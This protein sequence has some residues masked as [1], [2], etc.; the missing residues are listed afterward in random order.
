MTAELPQNPDPADRT[1]KLLTAAAQHAAPLSADFLAELRDRTT[2]EFQQTQRDSSQ[3]LTSS[4]RWQMLFV[5]ALTTAIATAAV[6]SALWFTHHP[7]SG[8]PTGPKWA[9]HERPALADKPIMLAF[10]NLTNAQ[11]FAA[12]LEVNGEKQS[13]SGA[14]NGLLRFDTEPGS[15]SIVNR[16]QTWEVNEADNRAEPAAAEYFYRRDDAVALNPWRLMQLEPETGEALAYFEEEGT[17]NNSPLVASYFNAHFRGQP[18]AVEAHVD[19]VKQLPR[20]LL[21]W[22]RENRGALPLLRF[23]LTQAGG[24]ADATKFKLAETL[25]KDGRIGKIVDLQG[26]VTVR[27]LASS[28]WTPLCNA[29]TLLVP[30][31]WLRTDNRG[32]NAATVQLAPQ[33]KLIVGPGTLLEL[34]KPDQLRLTTGVLQITA[35]D[36]TPVTITGPD[37][38]QV[39]VKG[40]EIWHVAQNK[41]QKLKKEPLWLTGYLGQATQETLGSLIALVDGRNVPLTV[42]YHKVHVEIRDQIA[43]TTIEESFVNHTQGVLE[44]KFY[45]PLP[46][47]ASISG[48][49]MWIGDKLVEADIVEKQRAREIY[50]TILREKR[51]PGLL[52][53]TGGN[54]FQARV[55]PIP[56]RSEKR[57]KITYTQVLPL[58][59]DSYRYS[60][61]LQSDLLKQNP[62]RKLELSVNIHS[63]QPLQQVVCPTHPTRTP[64]E[65]AAHSNHLA[66][67][68]FSAQDYTPTR[69]FEVVTTL[70]TRNQD[71]TLI[72]HQRGEDGFFM[73]LMQPPNHSGQ[74]KRP[75]VNDGRPLELL[76]LADT[77]ASMDHASRT[78][79]SEVIAALLGSLAPNDKFNL[80]VCDVDCVW[81]FDKTVEAIPEQITKA[82]DVLL[83]RR[84]MGWTNLQRGWESALA[85]SSPGAHIIYVGDGIVTHGTQD[86][87][88]DVQAIAAVAKGKDVL[89]HAIAVSSS[90][91]SQLLK[92][93][94]A[95][96]GGSVRHAAGEVKPTQIAHELLVEAT[97][98]ALRN[99]QVS[100]A[101]FRTAAVYPPTLANLP[102]GTQQ[103]VLGRYLPESADKQGEVIVSGTLDG[104]PVA[105]R[106]AVDLKQVPKA[107]SDDDASFIPRLWARLHL[108]ELLAQGSSQATQDQ[109][110]ALS[111]EYHIITPYTSLLVLE[112]DADRERFKVKKRV[113]MRDGER[114][115]QK[116]NNNLRYALIQQQLQQAQA[117]RQ[118]LR[119]R[120]LERLSN[121]GR[122]ANLLQQTEFD[123]LVSLINSTIE[124]NSWYDNGITLLGSGEMAGRSSGQGRSWN[125]SAGGNGGG[126]VQADF[127]FLGETLHAEE[128]F[129][130]RVD[131]LRRFDTRFGRT[132]NTIL[133]SDSLAESIDGAS[134]LE[135]LQEWGESKGERWSKGLSARGTSDGESLGLYAYD[136]QPQLLAGIN[137]E[138]HGEYLAGG[139]NF[140]SSTF[141]MNGDFDGIS[142][143]SLSDLALHDARTRFKR[144]RQ[145]AYMQPTRQPLLPVPPPL[146]LPK[147]QTRNVKTTWPADAIELLR[148]L[149]LDTDLRKLPGGLL[150]DRQNDAFDVR[151]AVLSSR[152]EQRQ[153]YSPAAWLTRGDR[154]RETS[155]LL[156]WCDQHER[157]NQALAFDLAL[158]RK[159]DANDLQFLPELLNETGRWD[160]LLTDYQVKLE[161]PAE[162]LVLL[163]AKA[164]DAV[165]FG[166]EE[167]RWLIDTEQRIVLSAERRYQDKLVDRTEF[168]QFVQIAGRTFATTA[169][170]FDAEG[171]RTG[172]VILKLKELNAADFRATWDLEQKLRDPAVTFTL[173]LP[174]LIDAERQIAAGSAKVEDRLTLLAQHYRRRQWTDAMAQLEA[175]EQLSSGKAGWNWIRLVL[176]TESRRHE[177][178]KQLLHKLAATTSAKSHPAEFGIVHHL[179]QV[180][181]QRTGGNEQ[182]ALLADLQATYLRFAT[183]ADGNKAWQLARLD[184][185]SIAGRND[186]NRELLTQLAANHPRDLGLQLQLIGQLRSSGDVAAALATITAALDRTGADWLEHESDQLHGQYCDIL[187]SEGRYADAATYA[188][189]WAEKNTTSHDAYSRQLAYLVLSGQEAQAF[190]TAEEWLKTQMPAAGQPLEGAA[191]QK[192]YVA[193]QLLLGQ[194]RNISQANLNLKYLPQLEGLLLRRAGTADAHAIALLIWNENDFRNT[195]AAQRVLKTVFARVQDQIGTLPLEEVQRLFDIITWNT[196]GEAYQARWKQ[197]QNELQRRWS[198]E[199]KLQQRAKYREL[200]LR[201]AE[202][203]GGQENLYRAFLAGARPPEKDQAVLELFNFLLQQAWT[204]EREQETLR[205][206]DQISAS[207][208]AA[209]R[210]RAQVA[211]LYRWTDTLESLRG[212]YLISKINRPDK[213]K[214][215]DLDKRHEELRKQGRVEISQ[216]LATAAADRKNPADPL[217]PWLLLEH[218]TL[219]IR[220]ER[221]L[222]QVADRLWSLLQQ[223]L[224][225]AAKTAPGEE[226][227]DN[228]QESLEAAWQQRLVQSLLHL[229]ARK[230]APPAHVQRLLK[231]FAAERQKT[232]APSSQLDWQQLQ[233]ELLLARDLPQELQQ[234]L[235]NFITLNDDTGRWRRQLAR[236][237]AELNK[238]EAAVQVMEELQRA[239]LLAGSDYHSLATWYHALDQRAKHEAAQVHVYRQQQ[240]WQLQRSLLQQLQRWQRN[241]PLP[242]QLDPNVLMM[243]AALLQTEDSPSEYL[244]STLLPFYEATHDP[245]LLHAMARALPGHTAER[246]Y[247]LLS[248]TCNVLTQ[249]EHEA[250]IDELIAGLDDV[251]KTAATPLDQRALDLLEALAHRRAAE[252]QNGAQPHVAAALAALSRAEKREWRA[253]EPQQMADFLASLGVIAQPALAAEQIRWLELLGKQVEPSSEAALQITAA[254]AT[255]EWSYE[256][257]DRALQLLIAACEQYREASGGKVNQSAL[258]LWFRV[259]EWQSQRGQFVTAESTL[260]N[261]LPQVSNATLAQRVIHRRFGLYAT[262]IRAD[263]LTSL[264]RGENLYRAALAA[265]RTEAA[266]LPSLKF[267][268]ELSN[269]TISIFQAAHDKQIASVPDDL[270]AYANDDF[271][272]MLQR[273]VNGYDNSADRMAT[274]LHQIAG[275]KAGIAFLLDR[276]ENEPVWVR[277]QGNN[278]W[279]RLSYRLAEWRSQVKELGDL[280]PRL[281]KFVIAELKRDLSQ[282]K[283]RSRAM[284]SMQ[285]TF[286]WS[287]KADDFAAAA[288]AVLKEHATNSHTV[289]FVGEYL[290]YGLQRYDRAFEIML[291]AFQ[292]QL[293]NDGQQMRLV[294]LLHERQRYAESIPILVGL[295]KRWPLNLTYRC[296]LMRA[297]FHAKRPEA[298]AKLRQQTHEVFHKENR[299]QENTM[300][301]LGN[302]CL[303]C[304]L[305]EPAVEY[306]QEAI[307]AH[308]RATNGRSIGDHTLSNQY[309]SLARGYAGLK[310]TKHA[311]D[312]ASS[313]IICWPRQ[314]DEREN[315]LRTLRNVLHASP[316]LRDYVKLLD[317]ETKEQDRPIV[318]KA[319]AQ[320]LHAK[321]MIAEAI[322]QYREAVQLSPNDAELHAK[323]I[324]CLDA[325]MD[326]AGALAQSFESLE[327]NRRNFALWQKV[328]ERFDALSDATEAE[329]ARTSLAEVA[330]GETEGI[331]LLAQIR[332]RQERWSDA[333]EQWQQ[334]ARLRK[335][336]PTGLLNMARVQLQLG[337]KKAAA[338]SIQQLEATTWP[339]HFQEELQQKLPELKGQLK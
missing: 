270:I 229:A 152:H 59:G 290:Y 77:S 333:L 97:R 169:E 221:K 211:A 90:Y 15:Y 329:R 257:R 157:G 100:F 334:V 289:M 238:L 83:K 308:N 26:L 153:L 205:L 209:N 165:Q 22:P 293:L 93:I 262:A 73:L 99:I 220:L 25:T 62:L 92:A 117:W 276:A 74:W 309:Q 283:A 89:G 144:S 191:Y 34:P 11:S 231:L 41:L 320:V 167:R 264:G 146:H 115:F 265:A 208:S 280:E 185:L 284:Y 214:R 304:E 106:A 145:S 139:E 123:P 94:A 16:N 222:P 307:A 136:P 285:Y 6:F 258:E 43:R 7:R 207:A 242:A 254:L 278:T 240:P 331:T 121:L 105:Y 51:D 295:V 48:F 336:E 247:P 9:A 316:D 132:S 296:E 250:T 246:V 154:L 54:I 4:R 180:S 294:Q 279:D 10:A 337:Q 253:G 107:G 72:P 325:Q 112:T 84:S 32:A 243:F 206:L 68:E 55:Y 252:L 79:Q 291:D 5:R 322:V 150:I 216:R 195:P 69:D 81:T 335:L 103:V 158:V 108:D 114:F 194:G 202:F 122:D 19:P 297:Y 98:P 218:L 8:R 176:L 44:G 244:T 67:L 126:S 37:G 272:K 186:E 80:A 183:P 306:L 327:L 261:L 239:G 301:E 40:K 313:A 224:D 203:C 47:D 71:L 156:Q 45:F 133:L 27:A 160:Q 302:A 120:L 12:E 163:I 20:D 212:A 226:E 319:L 85:K 210:L 181:Q 193:V 49:G 104:K 30:G 223:S 131:D 113:Q 140:F 292:R 60:Y 269:Q 2:A 173:P 338:E 170:H 42:G 137:L 61:A 201:T 311:V 142:L 235:Q 330:P 190:T 241:G 101:G 192:V 256:R 102:A 259:A 315:A 179:R 332:E 86:L 234:L 263:G 147:L 118:Q 175:A 255:T 127:G 198:A 14:E 178:A 138:L 91:E 35:S 266:K 281:L 151:T 282:R 36:K 149:E 18:V 161:R 196:Q 130:H 260:S 70:A 129:I 288:E 273:Q 95:V 228:V 248:R 65:K 78:R 31:D 177:E 328:A 182:L 50:E 317:Q 39:T 135:S 111:E 87:A 66:R 119:Q 58:V 52:E 299:W 28:R 200:L 312:A 213:M 233:Y 251:R 56:A 164:T 33:T 17:D 187:E 29:N 76:I 174:K 300:T 110:I 3:P 303:D 109:I 88:G 225:R 277:Y 155:P 237:Y 168:S 184:A 166:Y 148:S 227:Y 298:L 217:T 310:N 162:N 236:V 57:I 271:T 125:F 215:A 1:S 219:E 13:I 324:E 38:G 274:A 339:E 305:F 128:D 318:R 197:I 314:Q 82:R 171:K 63:T 21:V 267:L 287:E 53:W 232:T 143:A 275:P 23:R 141:A 321:G 64:L 268:V 75:L 199:V 188:R 134:Q 24:A 286:Y 189:A 96:G 326:H 230:D 159:S 245:R 172:L 249:V 323:L 46:Q 116:S 204:A 124:P